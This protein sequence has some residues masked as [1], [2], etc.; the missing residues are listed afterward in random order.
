MLERIALVTGASGG[1]GR[2]ISSRLARDGFRVVLHYR[3][4]EDKAKQLQNELLEEGLDALRMQADLQKR[5]DAERLMDTIIEKY[6]RIDV[7][8]NNAGVIKDNPIDAMPDEDFDFVMDVNVKGPWLLSKLAVPH[9]KKQGYGRIVNISSGTGSHGGANKSN[10][11]ASKGAINTL[12][13][14]LAKELGPFG[15]TVN[16]VEPGMIETEMTRDFDPEMKKN[17]R[18]RIP[19]GKQAEPKDVAYA[20]SFF[21]SEECDMISGQLLGVNGGLR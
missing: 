11:G 12:T 7:L 14:S 17:Y 9:M 10:Y 18:S 21:A 8:V 1:L 16:A 6:G 3:S 5:S 20:V 2:A 13:K 19:R 15:I 4:H